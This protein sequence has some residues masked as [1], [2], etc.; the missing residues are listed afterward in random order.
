MI[1]TGAR[2][3]YPPAGPLV[4]GR[5]NT[6]NDDDTAPL[7]GR[8]ITGVP[9]ATPAPLPAD[10]RQPRRLPPLRGQR[11]TG[12]PATSAAISLFSVGRNDGQAAAMSGSCA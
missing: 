4:T 12:S 8:W 3:C 11:I 1:G 2:S 10:H 5:G 9:A 6:G 7:R